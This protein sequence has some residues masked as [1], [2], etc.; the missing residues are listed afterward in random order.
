MFSRLTFYKD[1]RELHQYSVAGD[2]ADYIH[3]CS[4]FRRWEDKG[5][6]E[7][8]SRPGEYEAGRVFGVYGGDV[9]CCSWA[10]VELGDVLGC[11]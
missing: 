3:D 11:V 1:E 8:V 4:G 2:V 10:G 7:A 5:G 9:F 6:Y